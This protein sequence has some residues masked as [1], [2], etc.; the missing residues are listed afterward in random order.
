MSSIDTLD[1]STSAKT[2]RKSSKAKSVKIEQTQAGLAMEST[3][4]IVYNHYADGNKG[5]VGK[6][7]V[8]RALYEFHLARKI[9]VQGF[10]ANRGT[11]DF[12]G[13]YP[14]IVEVG[15]IVDFTENESDLQSLNRIVNASIRDRVNTVINMPA[16]ADKR[17]KI[18]L[19]AFNILELAESNKIK[20]IR[21]FVTTGEYDSVKLL[22][23]S[24]KECS[25]SIQHIVVK[26]N[27][28]KDWTF[29][30][31]D[32]EIQDLIA[33]YNCKVINFP[34][35]NSAVT[36]VILKNRLSYTDA[37]AYREPGYFE[38]AEQGAVRGF[39]NK[40][41]AAFESTDLFW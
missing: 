10:E 21:W 11:P 12:G 9:P 36:A 8:C 38:E 16:N 40:A 15:N 33:E 6:S 28:F 14:E 31:K 37:C 29:F 23:L 7:T 2:A 34:G 25:K 4:E 20:L 39:M 19:D 3:S 1:S 41:F 18:W 27:K 13:F 22:G 35:L 5:G 30:E 24:L 26:N 32:R 17:F